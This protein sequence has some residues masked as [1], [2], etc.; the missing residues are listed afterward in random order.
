MAT[1]KA[2][3]SRITSADITECNETNNAIKVAPGSPI[4]VICAGVGR[5]GTRDVSQRVL[6]SDMVLL[7]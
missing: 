3:N 7:W 6:S 1:E 2:K 5:V 4:E